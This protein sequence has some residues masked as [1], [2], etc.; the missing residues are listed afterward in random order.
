MNTHFRKS[1]LLAS[2]ITTA[3]L[4]LASHADNRRLGQI[5]FIGSIVA[6]TLPGQRFIAG[7]PPS[8]TELRAAHVDTE[9]VRRALTQFP[10]DLLDYFA[11]YANRS[12]MLVTAVYP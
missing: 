11:T 2:F 9:S 12:A 10:I 3:G 1:L 8:S 5:H 6:P 4:S 7:L